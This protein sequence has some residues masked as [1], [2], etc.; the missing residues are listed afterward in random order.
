MSQTQYGELGHTSDDRIVK[1]DR[2]N[3]AERYRYVCLNGHTDWYRTNNHVWCKGC[4]RQYEAGDHDI[5]P[6][7]YEILDK[8]RDEIVPWEQVRIAED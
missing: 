5:D 1:I 6:E 8:K 7:H 3:T 2:S 4:R